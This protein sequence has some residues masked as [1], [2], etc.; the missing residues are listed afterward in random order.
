MSN[1]NFY[2]R[3]ANCIIFSHGCTVAWFSPALLVLRSSNTPLTGTGA[4]TNEQISWLGSMGSNGAICETIICGLLSAFYGC[5]KAMIF[6]A[7]PGIIFW[8]LVCFGKTYEQILI[9]RLISGLTGGGMQAGVALYV[10]EI[11][12]DK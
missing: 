11:S 8:L 12:S 2:F 7:F 10:S 3:S 6:L 4:L 1:E 9:G 5:K